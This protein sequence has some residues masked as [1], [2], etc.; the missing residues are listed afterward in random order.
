M[1]L[2]L[3]SFN[4]TVPLHDVRRTC[5]LCTYNNNLGFFVVQMFFFWWLAINF[6][7]IP[8]KNVAFFP[9][10]WNVKITVTTAGK[11]SKTLEQ[12]TIIFSGL[13]WS[14]TSRS[15][16]LTHWGRDKMAA[17][18]QTTI[19]NAFSWMKMYEFRLRFHWN[20]FPGV[21]LTIFQKWFR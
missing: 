1:N 10:N 4:Y 16:D 2:C 17:I 8:V 18:F 21:Q 20:L 12:K 9:S 14:K 3:F 11:K 6:C 15:R 19:W 5:F 13:N 7:R